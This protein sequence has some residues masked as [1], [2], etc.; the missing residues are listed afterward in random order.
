MSR[1]RL[2]PSIMRINTSRSMST[3][4]K[5]ASGSWQQVLQRAFY[6]SFNPETSKY[7]S[8]KSKGADWVGEARSLTRWRMEEVSPGKAAAL[9]WAWLGNTQPGKSSHDYFARTK[10]ASKISKSIRT[11]DAGRA[12][13]CL[14]QSTRIF[15]C[16]LPTCIYGAG[17]LPRFVRSGLDQDS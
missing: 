9:R 4:A 10:R 7:Y 16:H 13:C 6:T 5:S 14:N 2:P 17:M 15:Q 3:S 8:L 1:L 11:I 12:G